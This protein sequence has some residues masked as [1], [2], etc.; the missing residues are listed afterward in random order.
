[1]TD[2]YQIFFVEVYYSGDFI[3]YRESRNSKRIGRILAIIRQDNKLKVKIQHVLLFKDLPRNL[4]SINRSER[5]KEGEIWFL[6]RET[7]NA[8]INIESQAIV[9]RVIVSILYDDDVTVCN[10]LKI[11]EILYKHNGHW[12]LRSVKYSYKHPSEFAALEEP[13][14]NIPIYKLYI[15]LY[16]DDFGT[17]R[18]IYHSLGGVYL[19]IGR[20]SSFICFNCFTSFLTLI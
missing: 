2:I 18:N 12:K 15:D 7:N 16:Y 3:V 6:D 10:T 1:M 11:R 20:F 4:Q 19:Q 13:R 14:T 17:F 9:K 5:F 8:I